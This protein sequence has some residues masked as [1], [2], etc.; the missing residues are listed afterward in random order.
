MSALHPFTNRH[1]ARG[2]NRRDNYHIS[3][4]KSDNHRRATT[5]PGTMCLSYY[6]GSECSEVVTRT[7]DRT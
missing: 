2:I 4:L 1:F 6:F 3:H 5:I 7:Q